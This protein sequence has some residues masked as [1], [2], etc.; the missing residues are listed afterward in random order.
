M[1]VTSVLGRSS[2]SSERHDLERQTRGVW[3]GHG[4]AYKLEKE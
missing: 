1:H 3:G 2:G 4:M